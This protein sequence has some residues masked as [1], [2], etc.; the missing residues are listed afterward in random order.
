V[1]LRI[2]RKQVEVTFPAAMSPPVLG[3]RET[4]RQLATSVVADHAEAIDRDGRWPSENMQAL[5]EAGLLGLAVSPE[6]GGR[7]QG[8]LA[9]AVATE[10]LGRVCGSTG[11][12]F[13]MHC[14]AAKVLD[15]RPT[16]HQR[17][18]YLQPIAAGEHVTSLALSEPGTGVHFYLPRATFRP[19]GETFAVN[20]LKA[21]STADRERGRGSASTSRPVDEAA[22]AGPLRTARRHHAAGHRR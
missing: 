2:E 10:E 14:V 4:A 17:E 19:K 5:G 8:M 16:D 11:L 1:R 15:V 21:P 6:V 22:R 3:V 13:G 20:G 9:L 18:R 12:V 7:G